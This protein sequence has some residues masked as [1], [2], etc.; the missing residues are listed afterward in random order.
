MV[1]NLKLV[2]ALALTAPAKN[3]RLKAFYSF[4]EKYC[5]LSTKYINYEDIKG[6][7][8]D[9]VCG[10][11]Q[12]WNPDITNGI[13]PFYFGDIPGVSN[14]IS[15]AASLGRAVYNEEDELKAAEL[16]K[17]ID[18]ISVREEKSIDY[19][20]SISDK[21]AIGASV[22]AFMILTV[23]PVQ[24]LIFL[25][26][27]VVLQQLEGNLIYPKVV[28]SSIGLPGVWV[29]AAVTIGGGIS[30]YSGV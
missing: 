19:I 4:R 22:G 25:I 2:A 11:D 17:K 1:H 18:Y 8:T 9:V 26:F 20:K 24:A 7:Y 29:L 14:R 21:D 15:Y 10:S 3:K 23:S 30:A 6:G 16:I 12:I 28:G 13:D 5:K 27:V